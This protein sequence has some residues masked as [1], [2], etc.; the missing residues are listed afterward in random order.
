[1]FANDYASVAPTRRRSASL[2]T[3]STSPEPAPGSKR[4]LMLGCGAMGS[5]LLARWVLE[6]SHE[7][8]IARRRHRA[9]AVDG[10]SVVEQPL[11]LPEQSL[12][13]LVIAVKPQQISTAL[14]PWLSRLKPDGVLVSMAAGVSA[15]SLQQLS[16]SS[17]IIR[18]MPN[19]AVRVGRGICGVYCTDSVTSDQQ[20]GVQRLLQH[21]GEVVVVEQ[22]ADLDRITAVACGARAAFAVRPRAGA[23]CLR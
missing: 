7:L 22:E 3:T 10:I 21:T 11:Q 20:A 19:L 9:P 5:A 23:R 8:L 4:T 1:M 2:T 18:L 12:D 16:G 15:T 6:P 17:R 13:Y 14:K